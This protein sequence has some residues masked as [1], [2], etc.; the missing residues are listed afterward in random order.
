[1]RIAHPCTKRNYIFFAALS[2]IFFFFCFSIP[3]EAQKSKV[4]QHPISSEAMFQEGMRHFIKDD[5][6]EAILVWESLV[7]T[8]PNEPAL[9]FYLA[10][11]HL[12]EKNSKSALMYAQKAHELSP[13]SL[14]YGLFFAEQLLAD[15]QISEAIICLNQLSQY[16]ESHPEVNLLL[17]QAYLW[18]EQGSLALKALD[19]ADAYVGEYPAII[20]TKEFIW[21]KQ[22]QLGN[23]LKAGERLIDLEETEQILTWDQMDLAWDLSQTDSIQTQLIALQLRHPEQGQLA[24]LLTNSYVHQ[25]NFESS[26]EQIRLAAADHEVL[27]SVVAQVTMKIFELIDNPIKWEQANQLAAHWLSLYPNEPRFLAIQ[28]DLYVSAS[29]LEEGL[30][31]YLR[32]ARMGVPRYEVWQRIIQL[33]FELNAI[34]SASTH[35]KE[36]LMHFPTQGFLNF[37]LGFAFYLQGNNQEA[38]RYLETARGIIKP[39]DNWNLQLFSMLGDVYHALNRPTESDKAFD[40]VLLINPTDDHVLN[41]YSYY[42]SLRKE[43]LEKAATMSRQ[44]VDKLPNEGTYLDTYAWV[45]YQQGNYTEALRYLELAI[46]DEKS[47]SSAV[48]EHHGDALYRLGRFNE[49][50]G[51]WKKAMNLPN[52]SQNLDKKIKM[53]QIVE[54]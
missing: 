50:V 41:N 51:S 35:A 5:Y 36:A 15:K 1:M 49:A 31:F 6:A 52:A 43:H 18:S 16:D 48:W 27:P 46:A 4:L 38:I 32:A 26:L 22:K 44:L 24:L 40:Q 3:V 17:A 9:A 34:D 37:Q 54:N 13:Y 8:M 39:T 53:K 42:L 33:D 7:T 47:Q 2:L 25:K 45:L 14:D 23:A 12:L 29:K 28:G 20:R 19:R 30:R 11:A 10:K 21:L